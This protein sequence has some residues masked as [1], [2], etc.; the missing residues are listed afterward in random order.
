MITL[1]GAALELFVSLLN[2]HI[3]T[4]DQFATLFREQY[5]IN[6]A[7]PRISYAVFDI[8][9]YQGESLKE[10][11]NRFGV[12]VV[13]LKPTN[14]AMTVHAFTKGMLPVRFSE[15]LLRYYPK[16]FCEIRR[17]A[18]AHIAAEKRVTEKRG[19]VGPI[20]PRT[21]GRPQPMRVHERRKARESN[22]LTRSPGP[23]NTREE[24]RSPSTIFVLKVPTKTDKRFVH[25]KNAWCEF[26][27]AYGHPIR[28]CLS[29]G[30]QLDELVKS[31]FLK[32]YLLESQE[33]K[34]L[35]VAGI[36]Q[37]H[38]VPISGE[39]NTISGGFSRGGCI[40]SQQKKYAREVIAT[41]VQ[42]AD[43]TP[44]VDL[45]FTKVDRQ[46]VIPHGNDPVVISVV[47]A[48]RRVHRV[49]VD[50]GSSTNVMFWSTFNKLQLYL[51]Q[52]RPYTGCL[53]GFIRD[54]VEMRGHIL[55][56]TTLTDGTTSRTENIRYL[57][58]NAPLACNI[59][60]GRLALNRIGT[61]AS[62]RHM[63]M[64]LPSLEGT[65]IT[66]KSD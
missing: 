36:V 30:H 9:Q 28:N 14:E 61:V 27:H 37:G 11:L 57:V 1:A 45:V 58:V 26:H 17:R 49:L 51:D 64:K 15:S 18:M 56:R 3:T 5:L 35:V 4:F 42:E 59:I 55:L 12:Q 21:A 47:T 52:L 25:N 29:L 60:L 39:I 50:Q 40:A 33:D 7:P 46:D 41:E 63:K 20:Q 62:T 54:Q 31:G 65:V 32:D 6:R 38:E 24:T 53:Y 19:F 16:M 43:H 34:T 48:G 13:R 23:K 66:I 8:K 44:N 22:N 10:F 2:G